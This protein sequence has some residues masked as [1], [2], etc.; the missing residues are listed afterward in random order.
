MPATTS[1][2]NSL[3]VTTSDEARRGTGP[4][5][6][7]KKSCRSGLSLCCNLAIVRRGNQMIKMSF[8]RW[9]NLLFVALVLVVVCQGGC[10]DGTAKSAIARE[11]EDAA[12]MGF[13][14]FFVLIGL[15]LAIYAYGPRYPAPPK[16][17]SR[18]INR[19]NPYVFPPLCKRCGYDLRA[20]PARCPECGMDI[21]HPPRPM[22]LPPRPKRQD[23]TH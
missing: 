1:S 12:A 21:V 13:F 10:D 23:K 22:I 11:A 17:R 19:E 7:S 15:P 20:S 9:A 5:S 14:V 3:E 2:P 4:R 16:L 8:S 18:V 6:F